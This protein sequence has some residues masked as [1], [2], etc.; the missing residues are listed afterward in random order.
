M[1]PQIILTTAVLIFLALFPADAATAKKTT[2]F[3]SPTTCNGAHGVARWAAKVDKE[4]PPTDKSQIQAIT[5]S[6]MY[7]WPGVGT[8]SKLG[9]SSKRIPTEQ[10]WYVLT[11]RVDSIKVE[12]DGDIHIELV[13]ADDNK[14]GTVGVEIPCGRIWGEFRKLV[15]SWTSQKF[16]FSFKS[17]KSLTVTDPHI[18]AVTGKAFYDVDHAPKDGSNERPKP[19][20]A[21]FSV[22][23]VHP[24][25]GITR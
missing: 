7:A 20:H 6:Q 19:F 10:K 5:P 16:P 1:T 15:F 11:G 8:K 12:A 13:D 2:T 9:Q 23:E 24:V 18:I 17:S 3:S 25:M 14:P 21:G 22:W 4:R